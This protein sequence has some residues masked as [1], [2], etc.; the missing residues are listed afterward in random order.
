MQVDQWMMF[1]TF[2]EQR[3]FAHPTKRSIKGVVVNANMVAHAP[4]GLAA[5]LMERTANTPYIID[6]Q[7]HAFQHNPKAIRNSEGKIKSSL[8]SLSEHFGEPISS[9]VSKSQPLKPS[10]FADNKLL[11]EFVIRCLEFQRSALSE[12]MASSEANKY[13]GQTQKQLEPCALLSP[14]FYIAEN[15]AQDWLPICLRLAKAAADFKNHNKLFIPL[16]LSKAALV[17]PKIR[18]YILSHFTDI[19]CDGFT[20]WIDDLNEHVTS[21]TLLKQFFDFATGLRANNKKQVINLH[22][23]YFSIL[24]GSALGGG[25]F[26]GVS[27]GPEFGEFRSVVPVGGG[28]PIARYYIPQLH[29]R[30][31]YREALDMFK[32]NGWLS[33]AK[34]FHHSVCACDTCKEVIDGNPDNFVNFGTSNS[35]LVRRGDGFAR[36]DFPT[37]E[38]KEN[39]L[40][41]YLER[42]HYEY[43]SSSKSADVLIADLKK[44][45]SDFETAFGA[46]TVDHL[47]TWLSVFRP[48]PGLNF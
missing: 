22:G 21:S 37:T 2:A 27:H 18:E 33:S 38:A 24:A 26:S 40:K 43:H 14:Y 9:C 1:S 32:R 36:V 10:N 7:T 28:I 25:A 39:C 35:K 20:I 30:I 13:L 34:E 11:N 8:F 19:A 6:P 48:E 41:H 45:I 29:A 46:D 4:D 12:V 16:V 44:G 23:G 31:R 15:T 47:R 42:K 5:F 3:F 17:R